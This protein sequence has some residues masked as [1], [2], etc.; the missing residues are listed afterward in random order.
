[1]PAVTEGPSPP[2][3]PPNILAPTL[4]VLGLSALACWIFREILLE[5]RVLYERDIHLVWEAYSAAFVRSWRLG[6][7]PLWD[8]SMGFGQSLVGNPAAQVFYPPTWLAL[9]LPFWTSCALYVFGHVLGSGAGFFALGRRLG[10]VR[11]AAFTGAALWM[12]SGSFLT[13]ASLWHHFAGAAWMPWVL[14]G[15]MAMRRKGGAAGIGVGS[16]P[17]AGQILAGSADLCVLTLV[18]GGT[19]LLVTE[20]DWARRLKAMGLMG[21]AGLLALGLT[22]AQWLTS[23]DLVLGSARSELGEGVRTYWSVHPVGLLDLVLPVQLGWWP[24]RPEA[25]AALY[26]SREPFLPSLYLGLAALPLV[27]AAFVHPRRRVAWLFAGIGTGAVL[28][29]LGRHAP[30]YGA[31]TTLVPPLRI[32]RYPVKAIFLAAFSWVSLAGLGME[33]W[34]GDGPPRKGRWAAGLLGLGGALTLFVA[35]LPRIVDSWGSRWFDLVAKNQDEQTSILVRHL[36][37]A[38]GA[39]V[40]AGFAAWKADRRLR[41]AAL[42]VIAAAAVLEAAFLLAPLNPTAPR[43]LYE[44]RPAVFR[45]LAGGP[46][47]RCYVYNYV[48]T[49]KSQQHLGRASAMVLGPSV[50]LPAGSGSLAGALSLRSYMFPAAAASWGLRYA[51]DLDMTGL[52]PREVAQ[53]DRL[54][55]ATEGTPAQMRLLRLG[56]VSHV[57]SLH[58]ER[59][60]GLEPAGDFAEMLMDPVRLWRVPDPLPR[61]LVVGGQRAAV[62]LDALSLLADGRVD[63]RRQV[64]LPEGPDAESPSDF[65]GASQVLEERPGFLK[66]EAVASHRG[67]LVIQDAYAPGWTARLDGSSVPLLRANGAF[68]AIAL[69]PGRHEIECRYLP[70]SLTW[71]V[72]LSFCLALATLAVI[73]RR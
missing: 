34:L 39:L 59:P 64:V 52:A 51:F 72:G 5:D 14:L 1:V 56:G 53:L 47:A 42:T 35:L 44:Y 43:A 36:G 71:G 33:V 67:H 65:Q 4:A 40:L 27:L 31:L 70:A 6:S 54:L 19:M 63:P 30:F 17:M 41:T 12:V 18:L 11:P 13:S 32:L 25:R 48:A 26:E 58:D 66:V 57:V 16:L 28:V 20:E 2:G 68:R 37:V 61:T 7:W 24:L 60:E 46:L 55:W 9:F 8:D 45:S 22:A 10:L 21:G 29:A 69:P 50:E 23:L 15:L 3:P 38:A 73:A 62:T 49:G